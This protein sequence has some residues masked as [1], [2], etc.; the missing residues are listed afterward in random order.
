M[1][2]HGPKMA[3]FRITIGS[4]GIG[5]AERI[6]MRTMERIGPQSPVE[7]MNFSSCTMSWRK[8]MMR[9]IGRPKVNTT[10]ATLRKVL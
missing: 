3:P 7:G 8:I 5:V 4:V 10:M 9:V 1:P 2:I 6:P